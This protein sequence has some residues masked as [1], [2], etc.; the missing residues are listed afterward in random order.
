MN[1]GKLIYAGTTKGGRYVVIRDGWEWD[2]C[3]PREYP[4]TIACDGFHLPTRAACIRRV[5]SLFG[6]K[7]PIY[8]AEQ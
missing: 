8:E 6:D 4:M 2:V 3:D 1:R 5:K 7:Y